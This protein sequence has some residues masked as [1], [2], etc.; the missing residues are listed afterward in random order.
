MSGTAA[1]AYAALTGRLAPLGWLVFTA[2]TAAAMAWRSGT[3][4]SRRA[5]STQQ[6]TGK[7]GANMNRA[8]TFRLLPSLLLLLLLTPAAAAPGD[9]PGRLAE[10][11]QQSAWLLATRHQRQTGD[12]S[13][14]WYAQTPSPSNLGVSSGSQGAIVPLA[15]QVGRVS[16]LRL[17]YGLSG[18]DQ[19]R[20]DPVATSVHGFGLT[21]GFGSL[22]TDTQ[23]YY[24]RPRLDPGAALTL[25]RDYKRTRE[26]KQIGADRLRPGHGIQQSLRFAT[27]SL[28]LTGRYQDIDA[29]FAPPAHLL[30]GD[31]DSEASKRL[32]EMLR[33]RGTQRLSLGLTA[34][35]SKQWTLTSAFDSLGEG[36]GK[37]QRQEIGLKGSFLRLSAMRQDVDSTFKELKRF[38]DPEVQK[39][40]VQRGVRQRSLEW[41]LTPTKWLSLESALRSARDASGDVEQRSLGVRVGAFQFTNRRQE[42]ADFKSF[43]ALSTAEQNLQ[44]IV[45]VT[46]AETQASLGLG[47]KTRLAYTETRIRD[48]G[49]RSEDELYAFESRTVQAR[50]Q[51]RSLDADFKS[52]KALGEFDKRFQGI[53]ARRGQRQ[54]LYDLNYVGS[55]RL[56]IANHYERIQGNVGAKNAYL[57][58]QLAHSVQLNL[59]RTTAQAFRSQAETEHAD[60]TKTYQR[61]ER[62]QL[63]HTLQ[64]DGFLMAVHEVQTDSSS[65]GEHIVRQSD[66]LQGRLRVGPLFDVDAQRTERRI[67]RAAQEF[68]DA[69]QVSRQLGTLNL[70]CNFADRRD[71]KGRAE[72]VKWT[73]GGKLWKGLSFSTSRE[74][75]IEQAAPTKPGADPAPAA[76]ATDLRIGLT[77]EIGKLAKITAGFAQVMAN[78]NLKAREE[79]L[80]LEAR[81]VGEMSITGEFT[82]RE[83]GEKATAIIQGITITNEPKEAHLGWRAQ[84]KRRSACLGGPQET[85]GWALTY[86]GEG[87]N[88]VTLTASYQRNAE[89][90]KGNPVPGRQV[91]AKLNTPLGHSLLVAAAFTNA[92]DEKTRKA[93]TRTEI[94][95]VDAI[96]PRERLTLAA[97]MQ[98]TIEPLDAKT[99][100]H[101]REDT[102]RAEYRL[103][104]SEDQCFVVGGNVTFRTER[105]AKTSFTSEFASEIK[106]V[107][108]F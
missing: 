101:A 93:L 66:T 81:P 42:V 77:Q 102:L 103:G 98:R 13:N 85:K 90:G 84:Y 12:A 62:L 100:K 105:A 31:T 45:G 68:Q 24:Y 74:A 104:T 83:A 106:W 80:R 82:Q 73:V 38:A 61:V 17:A 35:P 97:S 67:S 36:Q 60:D 53:D 26:V 19:K 1:R 89:D 16:Q 40:E 64:K 7:G 2:L 55:S 49:G 69:I 22:T 5:T 58:T 72:T 28:Q 8:L 78:E 18:P 20:L 94:S 39:L 44:K 37:M 48:A 59:G 70:A 91:S 79:T 9:S 29:T 47:G 10:R 63:R 76:H 71:A 88:P 15:L 75:K 14:R 43:K 57:R 107:R 92:M 46:L 95:L 99:L 96:S 41:G 25:V 108:S 65:K 50:A 33:E 86:K 51:F 11:L 6:S 52:G 21:G 87:K 4:P 54:A 32:Q 34:T 56:G 27:E 3:A 23:V 30:K